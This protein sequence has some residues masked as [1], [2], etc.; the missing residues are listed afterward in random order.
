MKKY[1]FTYPLETADNQ[2]ITD[3]VTDYMYSAAKRQLIKEYPESK[4]MSLE[5]KDFSY[6]FEHRE[7]F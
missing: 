4:L 5:R 7:R 1:R 6:P 2:T 3:I